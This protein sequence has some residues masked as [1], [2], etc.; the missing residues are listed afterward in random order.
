MIKSIRTGWLGYTGRNA[1][2]LLVGKPEERDHLEY[3]GV[4]WMIILKWILWKEGGKLWTGF[5][6]YKIEISDGLE[7]SGSK[8]DRE[9]LD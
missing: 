1:Y 5:I 9:Y 8:T 6:W 7:P 3:L 4:H 2:K